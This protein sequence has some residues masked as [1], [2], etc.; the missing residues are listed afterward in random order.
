MIGGIQRKTEKF[1]SEKFSKFLI[2]FVF[3]KLRK[4][5]DFKFFGILVLFDDEMFL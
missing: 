2:N 4:S 5:Y 1:Q 3:L